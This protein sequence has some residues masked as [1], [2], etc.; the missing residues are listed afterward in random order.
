MCDTFVAMPNSTAEGSVLF[1]KNSDRDPNEA[2]ELVLIEGSSHSM[3]SKVRC[4]YIEIPQVKKTCIIL[5]SKP[6]WIWGAEMG[7][8]EH[9]VVIGNEAVFT[10]YTDN[11]EPGLIGMDFLRLALE[12]SNSAAGALEVITSLLAEYGQSGNCGF[13]HPFYYDNSYLI[14]DRGEAWVLET[15]GRQW[16]A[17]KVRDI[18]SISNALTI[19]DHWDLASKD[20]VEEAVKKGW[21]KKRA[22][23]SFRKCYSDFLY[24]N[25]GAGKSRQAC[26]TDML[27]A[28]RGSIETQYMM[29]ILRNHGSARNP[30]WNPGSALVGADI[31]MHA[32]FG[33][34]RVS[35]TAGS[36]VADLREGLDSFWLTGTA[37]P[38]ISIFKPVWM[39]SGLPAWEKYPEGKFD[40]ST[41][42]WRGEELHRAILANYAQ[43]SPTVVNERDQLE[44]EWMAET[45]I[46]SQANIAT[47]K[48]KTQLTFKIA[49]Q[50]TGQWL[51]SI[52]DAN[53]KESIPFY[54]RSFRKSIDKQADFPN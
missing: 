32:G 43:R 2:Q 39:D 53:T 16:V 46:L 37:A 15:A 5:L 6:F 44:S 9:G 10:R 52:R 22:G 33:P 1:A 47:R 51:K 18:R 20:V 54:Y 23:F 8:N 28:K 4:T 24:T 50:I 38:C 34:V 26:S 31:C 21:C 40:P 14:A 45:R 42:W 29:S 49:D 19:E 30:R 36:M 11:K 27:T 48:A 3:G 41:L 12:R 25:F 17:E 35:Q 7:A 13:A